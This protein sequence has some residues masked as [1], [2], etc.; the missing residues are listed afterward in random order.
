MAVSALDAPR[1]LAVPCRVL[2]CAAAGTAEVA[3]E[4]CGC[5]AEDDCAVFLSA[6]SRTAATRLPSAPLLPFE[7]A[8]LVEEVDVLRGLGARAAPEPGLPSCTDWGLTSSLN[9]LLSLVVKRPEPGSSLAGSCSGPQFANDGVLSTGALN[10]SRGN[11][12]VP[13]VICG[14][15][16]SRSGRCACPC[17]HWVGGISDA[18]ELLYGGV[19]GMT[20]RLRRRELRC[21]MMHAAATATASTPTIAAVATSTFVGLPS[22][23]CATSP[24]LIVG[25]GVGDVGCAVGAC[26]GCALGCAVG[27]S[28]G[29]DVGSRVGTV[30]AAL[31]ALLGCDVVG[32]SVGC[33][34]GCVLGCLV[35]GCDVVGCL[36]VG[37]DV[38]GCG[39]L[40][41]GVVGAGL[42][43]GV[44]AIAYAQSD[45][46]SSRSRNTTPPIA[47][48]VAAQE[49]VLVSINGTRRWP[50]CTTI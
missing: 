39:V 25:F 40:G 45:S 5:D 28:L 27:C 38:V 23:A 18:A 13:C 46:N 3:F 8:L 19:S 35:V 48:R 7:S 37:C 4:R 43:D 9:T 36:V 24:A 29:R 10:G 22:G 21:G 14:Q 33:A 31:G 34:V 17:G 6:P 1:P 2:F 15:P 12:S 44:C 42:T 30:G 41:R 49:T 47:R 16:S 11:R 50:A 20:S 26:V 32:C